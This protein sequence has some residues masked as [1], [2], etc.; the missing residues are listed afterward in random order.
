MECFLHQLEKSAGLF[1]SSSTEIIFKSGPATA[2]PLAAAAAAVWCWSSDPGRSAT[3]PGA[4]LSVS[5]PHKHGV[6]EGGG[7][8]G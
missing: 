3:P 1:S 6:E 2:R 7:R 4:A 8:A 5:F